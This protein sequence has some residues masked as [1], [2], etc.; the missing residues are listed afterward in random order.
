MSNTTKVVTLDTI[1]DLYEGLKDLLNA[2]TI[3]P[4]EQMTMTNAF[5]KL[6]QLRTASAILCKEVNAT[7]V[8]PKLYTLQRFYFEAKALLEKYGINKDGYRLEVEFEIE[9]KDPLG[10]PRL[11]CYIR[12]RQESY[13]GNWITSG[14]STTPA[15]ALNTFEQA[16]QEEVGIK[17]LEKV[18]LQEEC[19]IESSAVDRSAS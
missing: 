6:E 10:A 12:Y 3:H 4:D 14:I 15:H 19:S 2:L 5:E 7:P 11:E 9:E 18:S 1:G 16:L 8:Q 17:I 13:N